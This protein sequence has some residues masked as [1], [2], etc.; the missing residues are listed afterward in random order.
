MGMYVMFIFIHANHDEQT[1][2]NEGDISDTIYIVA[3]SVGIVLVLNGVMDFMTSF[4]GRTVRV[5][6][7]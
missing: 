1:V 4:T 6:R 3:R 7:T 5:L 2:L